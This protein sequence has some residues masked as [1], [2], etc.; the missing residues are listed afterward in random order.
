MKAK[1]LIACAATAAMLPLA[2]AWAVQPTG[3][4]GT[5]LYGRSLQSFNQLDTNRDGVLSLEEAGA[6]EVRPDP[7]APYGGP[8]SL[9]QNRDG[10]ISRAELAAL[11]ARAQRM[12]Y[13]GPSWETNP[14]APAQ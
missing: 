14:P 9:D 6:L 2:P 10:V 8:E 4:Q 5:D 1:M 3:P 12:P 13:S 7:R 11:D